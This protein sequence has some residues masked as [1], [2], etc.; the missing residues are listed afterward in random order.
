[1][2]NEMEPQH[3]LTLSF[4]NLANTWNAS[5]F[6]TLLTSSFLRETRGC[7]L[8]LPYEESG[9]LLKPHIVCIC[10]PSPHMEHNP[11]AACRPVFLYCVQLGKRELRL[12]NGEKTSPDSVKQANLQVILLT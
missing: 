11:S 9:I 4:S 1:M 10:S 6:S 7:L 8:V 3:L 2:L 5:T 12:K